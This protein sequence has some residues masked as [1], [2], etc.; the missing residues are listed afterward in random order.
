MSEFHE[1]PGKQWAGVALLTVG[2][3][4]GVGLL[5]FWPVQRPAP[6]LTPAPARAPETHHF[7]LNKIDD[8]FVL[9]CGRD[10]TLDVSRTQNRIVQTFVIKVV[11]GQDVDAVRMSLFP[12]GSDFH[13]LDWRHGPDGGTE[14][15]RSAFESAGGTDIAIG[16]AT[17]HAAVQLGGLVTFRAICS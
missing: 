6:V 11:T 1:S 10:T 16:G 5:G 2:L 4:G 8:I 12:A 13:Y 15:A 7:D 17:V 9:D 14:V 3:V